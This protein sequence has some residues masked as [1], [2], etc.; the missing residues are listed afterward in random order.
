MRT[1]EM[2][3]PVF[4]NLVNVNFVTKEKSNSVDN[5]GHGI[6]LKMKH[7]PMLHHYI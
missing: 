7:T 2:Y 1:N 6:D 3:E 4:V 5:Y